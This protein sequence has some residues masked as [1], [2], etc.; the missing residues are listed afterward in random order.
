MVTVNRRLLRAILCSAALAL[1]LAACAPVRPAETRSPSTGVPASTPSPGES[2]PAPAQP[3]EEAAPSLPARAYGAEARERAA[4]ALEAKGDLARALTQWKLLRLLEPSNPE[5]SRRIDDVRHRIDEGVGKWMVKGEAAWKAGDEKGA[6]EA[7]LK[8]LALNPLQKEAPQRLREIESK[9][10][11]SREQAKLGKSGAK[12]R[13]VE[14][15]P[16]LQPPSNEA[17]YYLETGI[18]LYREGDYEKSIVEFEKYLGSFPDNARARRYLA[19]AHVR[20]GQAALAEGDSKGAVRH[21]EA[22]RKSGGANAQQVGGYLQ[23]AKK[24]TAEELYDLGVKASRTDLG[25]AIEYWKSC[26]N[27]DPNHLAAR[28]Q[29]DRAIKMQERLKTIP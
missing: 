19:D 16:T 4:L 13:V 17:A 25:K 20:L 1:P 6:V 5:W 14:I 11:R 28:T 8:A 27:Y 3:E 24:K 2:P 12:T 22:A 15:V 29:L 21:F 9:E 10:I 18:E 23:Q 26:L 7:Y